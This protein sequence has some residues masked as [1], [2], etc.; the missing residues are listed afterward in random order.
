MKQSRVPIAVRRM[1]AQH[2]ESLRSSGI[3]NGMDRMYLGEDVTPIYRPDVE[4]PAYYEFEVRTS[5]GAKGAM[6]FIMVSANGHDHPIP[7]WN[8]DRPPVSA[9][10]KRAAKK[11]RKK[12]STIYK[13]DA[14]AYVAEDDN[15]K[16][17]G[18]IGQLPQFVRGLPDDL[19]GYEGR[20]AS[21]V[22]DVRGSMVTDDTKGDLPR[23][24][25]ARKGSKA[26]GVD[27]VAPRDWKTA[28]RGY[29]SRYRPLLDHLAKKASPAWEV[30]NAIREFGEGIHV[31]KTHT[32]ALL[33]PKFDYE[34]T[35]DGAKFVRAKVVKRPGGHSALELRA[36]RTRRGKEVDLRVHITYGDRT[37]EDLLFFIVEPETPSETPIIAEEG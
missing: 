31:G 18:H 15:E 36:R 11:E 22:A 28:K 17:V 37:K 23:H 26:K 4:E 35:G 27:L 13:L 9:E 2:L 33:H 14:L 20:V 6:G 1:A 34:I 8:L 30:E 21:A 32:M 19:S 12:V 25:L 16:M 3:K 5:A 29:G 7:H 24:T 10:L